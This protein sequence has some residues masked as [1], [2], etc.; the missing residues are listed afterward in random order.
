MYNILSIKCECN[1]TLPD[2]FLS[3]VPELTV[4]IGKQLNLVDKTQQSTV[5]A[6]KYKSRPI[7]LK[8]KTRNKRL[9]SELTKLSKI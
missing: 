7:I 5:K 9:T 6:I 2:Y 4:N 3:S 1:Y 8:H